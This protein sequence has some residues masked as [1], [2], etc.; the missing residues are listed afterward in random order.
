MPYTKSGLW[1]PEGTP[2]AKSTKRPHWSTYIAPACSALAAIVSLFSTW[3]IFKKTTEL[4]QKVTRPFITAIFV[5]ERPLTYSAQ[6]TMGHLVFK[7]VGN[8]AAYDVDIVWVDKLGVVCTKPER[9]TYIRPT[10]THRVVLVCNTTRP[11]VIP[12]NTQ[13]GVTYA[14][15]EIVYKDIHGNVLKEPIRLTICLG[16]LNA[17]ICKDD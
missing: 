15:G 14:E 17:P 5:Q 9:G 11:N 10:D 12:P 7:N 6:M 8:G 13:S 4:N 2:V 1:V 16:I 3:L